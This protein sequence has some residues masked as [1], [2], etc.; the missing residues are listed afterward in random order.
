MPLIQEHVKLLVAGAPQHVDVLRAIVCPEFFTG[1][2]KLVNNQKQLPASDHGLL[3]RGMPHELLLNPNL[4]CSS[5]V[6]SNAQR[7]RELRVKA[8]ILTAWDSHSSHGRILASRGL[9][10]FPDLVAHTGGG[11]DSSS[12]ATYCTPQDAWQ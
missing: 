9:D 1:F 3:L 7:F 10:P 8:S 2:V 5:T 6:R 4:I 11:H 12:K